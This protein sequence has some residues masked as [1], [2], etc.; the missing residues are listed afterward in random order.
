[1]MNDMKN[2][3][4]NTA[5]TFLNTLAAGA[6]MALAACVEISIEDELDEKPINFT[7]SQA[8]DP[9]RAATT[10]VQGAVLD[11]DEV[12]NI[13]IKGRSDDVQP[14]VN[15]GDYPSRYIALAP[16]GDYNTMVIDNPD[17][18]PYFPQG[19]HSTIDFFAA[20]PAN[21]DVNVT[22]SMTTFTVQYDQRTIRAYKNSDLMMAARTGVAKSADP[23]SLPLKHKMAKLIITA[24][25][26]DGVTVDNDITLGGIKR[27]V[28]ID[29]ENGDFDY[30]V[31]DETTKKIQLDDEYPSTP[32]NRTIKLTNGGAV[33]FPPQTVT[34]SRFIMVTGTYN[35]QQC[36]AQF[37]IID[38][39]FVEGHVYKLNL[40]IGKDDFTPLA[41]GDPHVSTITGWE[42]QYGELTVTPSGGYKGV[43]IAAIDGHVTDTPTGAAGE[44]ALKDGEAVNNNGCYVY[45][46]QECRPEPKV[47]YG[48][49]NPVTLVPGV[50]FKYT[51]VDNINS[52]EGGAQVMVIGQGA[53]AGLAALKP[54]TIYKA[55]GRISFP[56]GS[57]KTVTFNPDSTMAAVL[58]NNTGDGE[59]TY[60]AVADEEPYTTPSTVVNVHATD[61]EVTMQNQ[62]TARIKATVTEGRNYVYEAPN[63]TCTYRIKINPKPA[64]DPSI[65]LDYEPKN[66]TFD[67]TYHKLTRIVV[68]DGEHTL[69]QGTDYDTATANFYHHG[70]MTLEIKAKGNY[71]L[72]TTINIPI[73]QAKPTLTV[74]NKETAALRKKLLWLGVHSP[75][76]PVN[77]RKRLQATTENWAAANL[78]FTLEGNSDVA[79]VN[80]TS[81]NIAGKAFAALTNKQLYSE[82]RTPRTKDA[83]VVVSV[84]ADASDYEDW[85]AAD[86][87]KIPIRVVESDFTF[88]IARH[89]YDDY[90]EK[91]LHILSN[92]IPEGAHTRWTCPAKG[93]W[94]IDCYGA[95]GGTT[96]RYTTERENHYRTKA[97]F[98]AAITSARYTNQGTGGRGAHIA[99]RIN[100]PR[101]KVLHVNLGQKGRSIYPGEQRLRWLTQPQDD[102][103]NA[104]SAAEA[105]KLR[106]SNGG[107]VNGDLSTIKA[108]D[109]EWAAFAWNGGGGMIWGAHNMEYGPT[110]YVQDNY[111]VGN[112]GNPSASYAA[113]PGGV[114]TNPRNSFAGFPVTGGGGATDVSLAWDEEGGVYTPPTR[115]SE[116]DR[117]ATDNFSYIDNSATNGSV[118][119]I[120]DA[121]ITPK[122]TRAGS[123]TFEKWMTAHNMVNRE[124]G[125]GCTGYEGVA[126][127][128]REVGL[129]WKNPA[130]LY[131]RIIVAG[132]GGGALY[133]DSSTSA[134][135]IG[136]GG[137]GGVW[138]GT[139]GLYQ[140][141]GEG[142]YINAAGRGGIW[143]NW[144][145][146]TQN[147]S[148]NRTDEYTAG[149]V[150]TNYPSDIVYND[151]P[152]GGGWSGTDGMFGEGG[153]TFQPS[154]GCGGGGG[155]WYGGGAGCEDGSNGP[156]GGGSSFIWTDKESVHTYTSSTKIARNLYGIN[157]TVSWG[158]ERPLYQNYDNL[159]A[160]YESYNGFKPER[161]HK[162]AANFYQFMPTNSV[163]ATSRGN[164]YGIEC[165][166]FYQIVTKDTGANAG[167]G[168]ATITLVE[169]DDD[170]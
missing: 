88:R 98:G 137:N 67:G 153:N 164:E 31:I 131:S 24:I 150:G 85:I 114:S 8:F 103:G 96:P 4:R 13:Y 53:Y 34:T 81:G 23:V 158:T 45:T 1:M 42:E 78:R 123:G 73:A 47:T 151:G 106:G 55:K 118:T 128:N 51:Y 89:T 82:T 27:R 21:N 162:K 22:P 39:N 61:G 163:A 165:P 108:G 14:D 133:Y 62:G 7:V 64:N 119:L 69:I 97:A 19:T 40:H 154:Q 132:G 104:L 121:T 44:I 2:M 126:D 57:N 116:A 10:D 30:E 147:R 112:S 90:R 122:Y 152:N 136:D 86:T 50:D 129:Q 35:G 156:G 170:Q 28:K 56:E 169:I 91:Q 143:E 17:H 138:E 15:I 25:A 6:L 93:N 83:F 141:Y 11:K 167:D 18:Q 33:L 59:V 107:K 113:V 68:A 145:M 38:K 63:D 117:T 29:V 66:F 149:G 79:E 100:L 65:T 3:N 70:N 87:L 135:H 166:F 110:F 124:K 161:W 168:W 109:Y 134:G 84:E 102:N 157:H 58:V 92:G 60:A 37:D 101:G 155:G 99:G 95:E 71:K 74:K 52:S 139:R 5:Y 130:H 48:S 115:Y 127:G 160:D 105:K 75:T 43:D 16:D 26:D 146:G 111:W 142:G 72:D 125:V 20:Y 148:D 46:G 32:A 159:D 54:F 140:D 120:N 77:R 76:A 144:K 12:V 36:T 9:T 94:Q 49:V 41:N 80:A